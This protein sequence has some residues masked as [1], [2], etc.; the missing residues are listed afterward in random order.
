[1]SYLRDSVERYKT[2][3]TH[4]S[5]IVFDNVET[6]L[7]RMETNGVD[8]DDWEIYLSTNNNIEIEYGDEQTGYVNIAFTH[9][10]SIDYTFK[11][12]KERNINPEKLSDKVIH[13][14]KS[15][16]HHK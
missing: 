16:K 8:M 5:Q 3:D 7:D 1:M 13:S 12:N 2:Y 11:N 6:F 14:N 4:P 9:E 10:G 15:F